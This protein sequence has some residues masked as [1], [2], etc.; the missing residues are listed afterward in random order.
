MFGV[1]SLGTVS[2]EVGLVRD[3]EGVFALGGDLRQHLA[4]CR[5]SPTI[6]VR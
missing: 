5:R 3:E 6:F 4:K 2:L 1:S